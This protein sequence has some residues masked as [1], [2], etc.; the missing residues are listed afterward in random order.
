MRLALYQPEIAGNTGAV[1]RTC[2]ALGAPLDIIEP[3]GFPFSDRALARA[4]MDYVERASITR[5]VDWTA[6]QAATPGRIVLLT[7]RAE[8]A[9][10]D[11]AFSENDVLLLGQESAGVP[12][13]VRDACAHQIRIAMRPGIRSLNLSVSAAICLHEALRQTGQLSSTDPAPL[14]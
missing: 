2:A 13:S 8:L 12:E 14:G 7:T 4:G 1:I 9:L 6:F 10:Q 5:H 3:C 11:F